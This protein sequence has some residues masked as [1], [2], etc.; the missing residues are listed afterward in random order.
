[1]M[2]NW[3]RLLSILLTL[4]MLV[5]MAPVQTAEAACKHVWG[6]KEYIGKPT[7]IEPLGWVQR[8]TKCNQ[9]RDGEDYGPHQWGSWQTTVAATCTAGGKQQR[10]CNL[11]GAKETRDTNPKGHAFGEWFRRGVPT[12]IEPGLNCRLCVN[13][14]VGEF[15][16]IPA[17][18]HS[19]GEWYVVKAA[20]IGVAGREERQC[21]VCGLIEQRDIPPLDGDGQPPVDNGQEQQF[22]DLLPPTISIVCTSTPANGQYY[23]TDET[24]YFTVTCTNPNL[25]PIQIET[26]GAFVSATDF[27]VLF[28]GVIGPGYSLSA[29]I[30]YIV[31]TTDGYA[32]AAEYIAWADWSLPGIS[33]MRIET[34]VGSFPCRIEGADAA[35]SKRV[36][37]TPANGEF[38]VKNETIQYEVVFQ[39]L[40]GHELMNVKLTDPLIGSW[41]IDNAG[42][43]HGRQTHVFSFSY[44]VQ[45][46]DVEAGFVSNTATV[47][48][49]NYKAGTKPQ[50]S[51]NTVT[52]AC[53]RM[54]PVTISKTVTSTAANGDWYVPGEK[55]SF[56]VSVS[57]VSTMPLKFSLHDPLYPGFMMCS[58]LPL[59]AGDTVTYTYDYTVTDM[60]ALNGSVSNYAFGQA[61]DDFR[62][63]YDLTSAT[64]LMDCGFPDTDG[65]GLPDIPFGVIHGLSVTKKEES[66]PLNG[67][68]Y[69]EGEVIHYTITYT[70]VGELPL[71]DVEIFDLMGGMT[72]IGSAEKLDPGESRNCYYQHTVTAGD[73]SHGTV[74]NS[75]TGKFTVGNVSGSAT[76]NSVVSLTS[77]DGKPSVP[78]DPGVIDTEL[79]RTGDSYCKRVI[80]ARDNASASYET[81]F[82]GV[83]GNVQASVLKMGEASVNEKQQKRVAE[84]ALR[85]WRGE[86]E[87]LY[88]KIFSAADPVA[89]ANVMNE[90]ICFLT[91]M[92]NYEALLHACYPDQAAKVAQMIAAKWE[93]KCVTLCNEIHADAAQRTDS[94][95]LLPAAE[96]EAH[97]V[98]AIE[99]AAEKKGLKSYRHTYCDLHS[100]AFSMVDTL[101]EGEDTAEGWTMVRQIWEI[102]LESA[103]NL[104][105]VKLGENGALA[106][107]ERQTLNQWMP[108]REASLKALYPDNPELVEQT[109]A[110]IIMERVNDLC[111]MI[112]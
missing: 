110:K 83:H 18:G 53:G 80:T 111:Q 50:A 3:K 40:R 9:E 97:D 64:W 77:A 94:L 70:N 49:D 31:T 15:E 27:S 23:V 57:N 112:K 73:V 107:G 76:S 105:V 26:S 92:A 32:G 44:K 71:I 34:P 63:Y 17:N 5:G 99:L 66:L 96:G 87:A 68:Y 58:Q 46:E 91:D 38:Y 86:V 54:N 103:Y 48:W 10:T 8:C 19:F 85:L 29:N 4:I 47:Q 109:M 16:D 61:W 43:V 1:M 101:L 100:F 104:L 45:E 21:S 55:I 14:G 90:Y 89:K 65:D 95:L 81:Q 102:E 62:N 28:A 59:P 74:T 56:Q 98:C 25:I 20:Q 12:C 79:L 60:D 7:C 37:S 36:V 108:L 88:Q 35:V 39:N 42:Q 24:V 72:A 22:L 82:C 11:C 2:N 78:T 84:Y 69:V 41:V 51:T 52:V 13:C 67:Q 106:M 33:A 75:A 30:G 93:D 6:P